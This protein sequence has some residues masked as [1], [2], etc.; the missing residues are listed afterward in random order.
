VNHA[1]PLYVPAQ[2]RSAT[3]PQ[4]YTSKLAKLS[5]SDPLWADVVQPKKDKTGAEVLEEVQVDGHTEKRPVMQLVTNR[6]P[7]N[8][9]I[10]KVFQVIG[11]ATVPPVET[12]ED[13]VTEESA[14]TE[15]VAIG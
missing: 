11:L 10:Y 7:L 12:P 4:R 5:L 3:L 6:G 2:A 13:A 15:P 1:R 14:E 8:R 9:A